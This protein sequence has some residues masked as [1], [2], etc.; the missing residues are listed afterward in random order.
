MASQG[1]EKDWLIGE[2]KALRNDFKTLSISVD[3][4]FD[5]LNNKTGLPPGFWMQLASLILVLVTGGATITIFAI[6]SSTQPVSLAAEYNAKTINN[7]DTVLQ[8]EIRLINASQM[9]RIKA[10][11]REVFNELRKLGDTKK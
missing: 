7:L 10:L 11:E 2:F 4:R 9:V 8:R 6:Q 1:I 3:D 5:R